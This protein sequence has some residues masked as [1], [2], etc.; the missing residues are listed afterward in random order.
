[1]LS[2]KPHHMRYPLLLALLTGLSYAL[3][4][5]ANFPLAAA[6]QAQYVI[7]RQEGA[8]VAEAHAADDLA[9]TLKQITRA[10]FTMRATR[11]AARER[12]IIIGPGA[13]AAALFPEIAFDKLGSE[14]LVIKS[15]GPYLLLA[16][17]RPRGTLYAVYRFLEQQCGARW[18]TPWATNM[19]HRPTLSL[20]NLNIQ[21]QPAFEYREP[22]WFSAFDGDWAVRHFYNGRHAHLT[23]ALGGQ[24][25][26]KGF[27]HTFYE[28]V[29]P[30]KYFQPHPEW[31]SLI[32]G[33]RTADGAQLCLTNPQLRD[34]V[35][36]R[37]RQLLK[38]SPETNIIS[39]SQNDQFGPCE[40]DNCKAIDTAEGSHAGTMIAFVNYVAAKL[41][42]EFPNIAFDT[43]A[44]QYTRH[45]P[46]TIKPR[47]NVIV[48]LCSIECN[49]ATPLDD[50]SN[51]TFATDIRDWSKICG[52]LY[53]WDYVT[54]F[55]H[56][57]QPHPNWFVLGPN[58]R[59]FHDHHVRGVFEEGAYQSN[60]SEMEEMRAWVLAQLLWNP[61]A[62]DKA[63][64]NEFLNGY[65]GPRAGPY[66]RQYFDLLQGAAKGYY[67]SIGS[68]PDAPFLK[69]ATLSQA[70][71]L[72]QQAEAAA[73]AEPDKL[74]RVRQGH[75]PVRYVWLM[76][77]SQLQREA[78]RAGAAWPLPASRKAVAAAWLSVATGPGPAGW[79]QMTQINE[80]GTTPQ[81]FVSRFAIDPPAWAGDPKRIGHALAPADIKDARVAEGVDAQDDA[82]TLY[83]EGELADI[84]PDAAAS[85]G[86][87]AWMPGSHHEWAVQLP[88]SKLPANAQKGKWKVYA[89]IRVQKKPG[90]VATGNAFTA[91]IY[92][93]EAHTSRGD[94]TASITDVPDGYKSYLLG[95]VD[96]KPAAYFWVAPTG[97]PEVEAIWVDRFY[98][99]PAN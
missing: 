6:G 24:L 85:D 93:T 67:L 22:F 60:G 7:I 59:F 63:L 33:K 82:F 40:C 1:M 90:T 4:A 87:A 47:P 77:W 99:V 26:Y 29:P 46:K 11:P 9:A 16:G 32:N 94:A 92:D 15:K 74:W 62:D 68:P 39:I 21:E 55:G 58:M 88:T 34:F 36:E 83:R 27:V 96:I 14:E 70:E 44:Y 66:I 28:L 3:P 8:T 35:V 43:L 13:L 73:Q 49:F 61:N 75:L 97:T 30:A 54:N 91:G 25:T 86:V 57:V 65:Y 95:T 17:G 79:S 53:I 12:A 20:P 56:Y 31:Y 48:R 80:G 37:V 69:F 10:T 18:W 98:L 19:P 84:R 41:Q 2:T 76:R 50:P 23:P 64:I 42:P 89:V 52:R 72:W 51:A 38:E 45:P 5:E 71:K 78:A 81:A